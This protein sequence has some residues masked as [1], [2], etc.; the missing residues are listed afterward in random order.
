MPL[1]PNDANERPPDRPRLE[2]LGAKLGAMNWI[3]L[4]LIAGALLVGLFVHH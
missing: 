2:R 1:E 3:A 4:A